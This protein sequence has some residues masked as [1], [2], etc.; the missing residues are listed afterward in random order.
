M[1]PRG[2]IVPAGP[3]SRF[4]GGLT[5]PL[6]TASRRSGAAAAGFLGAAGL[7]GVRS[8]AQPRPG[9]A[10]GCCMAG[11]SAAPPVGADRGRRST[12]RPSVPGTAGPPTPPRTR[13]RPSRGRWRRLS[14]SG[15]R[16]EASLLQDTHSGLK[17]CVNVGT[18]WSP[19]ELLMLTDCLAGTLS[20]RKRF[21][22]NAVH[23]SMTA[24]PKTSLITHCHGYQQ[25]HLH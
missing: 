10:R 12:A 19:P 4:S 14:A 17:D 15:S 5:A 11:G 24:R 25:S 6:G 3:L 20:H 2:T 18:R 8:I 22:I 23:L 9:P 13:S 7:D 21:S 1:Q 16:G